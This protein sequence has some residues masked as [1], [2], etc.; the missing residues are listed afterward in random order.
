MTQKFL[1]SIGIVN[2]LAVI[3]LSVYIFMSDQKIVYVN[4]NKL[5]N[6]YKGMADAR[7]EY[8]KKTST[9]KANIDTLASE[10]QRQI[11]KYEE[12]ASSMTAKERQ[13]SQELVRTKQKQFSEYQQAVS[14][15]AQ[16]EDSKITGEV[17]TQVNAYLKKYGEEKGYKIILAATEYGNLAYADDGLDI[18]DEVLEGLNK[19]Y[20]G[21]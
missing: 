18:T 12:Q 7:A 13:L 5:L 16:Q 15:Q 6:S 4:S 10:I 17:I 2:L 3:A 19:E 9:W 20:S 14:T 21:K 11:F 8:E 1:V